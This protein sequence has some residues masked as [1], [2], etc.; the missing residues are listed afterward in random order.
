MKAPPQTFQVLLSQ[1][2]PVASSGAR[3][4]SRSVA[5]NGEHI[6]T[7][8][9]GVFNREVDSVARAAHLGP[10]AQARLLQSVLD[11]DLE[12]V[13]LGKG[14]RRRAQVGPMAFGVLQVETHELHAARA[15][16][17]GVHVD[18]SEARYDGDP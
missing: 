6:T 10:H 8:L 9:L 14:G 17:V 16:A 5:L 3:V 12:G 7:G 13:E 2:V 4:V 18:R 15:R 1:S 11:V